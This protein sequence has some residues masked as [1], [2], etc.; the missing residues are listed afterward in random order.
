M[1]KRAQPPSLPSP[2]LLLVSPQLGQVWLRL[3]GAQA[4]A[5]SASFADEQ[6][7]S[8]PRWAHTMALVEATHALLG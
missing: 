6:P 5:L 7:E 1:V 8:P 2:P 4:V 3:Q